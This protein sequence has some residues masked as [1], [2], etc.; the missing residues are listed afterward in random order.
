MTSY[1]SHSYLFTFSAKV[2]TKQLS[3]LWCLSHNCFHLVLIF[4]VCEAANLVLD[5]R[6]KI[7]CRP[8]NVCF[9]ISELMM[10]VTANSCISLYL[11]F[12]RSIVLL[13]EETIACL[14]TCQWFLKSSPSLRIAWRMG[15][16]S[17]VG[18]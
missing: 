4:D 9:K 5:S 3:L 11:K 13:M 2:S 16:I 12:D 18:Q 15:S 8:S 1:N 7:E 10:A 6:L 17:L 14:T